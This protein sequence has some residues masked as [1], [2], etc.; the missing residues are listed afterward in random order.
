MRRSW[1]V[2]QKEIL[3]TVR[4]S[5][6][7]LLAFVLPLVMYPCIFITVGQVMRTNQAKEEQAELRV[8]IA[9]AEHAPGLPAILAAARQVTLVRVEL[10]PA[11]VRQQLVEV[12]V[13]VPPGHEAAVLAGVPS[14]IDLYYDQTDALSRRARER[15]EEALV[16]YREHLL[17]QKLS[18]LGG[19]SGL[20]DAPRVESRNVASAQQM[21]AYVLGTLVPYLLVILIA[22]A[23]SHTAIDTT[24][25]EKERSTLET[26]L[27]SAAT[28]QELLI[29]KFLA[30]FATAAFA[31]IMGLLG[32][33]L[34]LS[35]PASAQAFASTEGQIVLPMW[36]IGVLL[37]MILP[38]A[39]LLSAILLVF[40][41]FARSAREGQ[42]F[43]SYF[44][45]LVAVIAVLSVTSEVQPTRE[46]FLIPI[47][48]TTQVQRLILSG[49]AVPGDVFLA[50]ASTIFVA[51]L[52]V[53]VALRLFANE[54]VMFR[55]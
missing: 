31:G 32:L 23:A 43:A 13:A 52:G 15:V 49:S 37:L 35:L 11:A 33:T 20:V 19:D 21:G 47:L 18:G 53:W 39:A 48:G 50:I 46:V 8:A 30:T 38:V 41:C 28:R 25:G 4:D 3:D 40:G 12:V 42:T 9:G 1:I 22:S 54:R 7:L 2:G 36:S 55:Q 27:V 45:M 5:R 51:A 44:I 10:G 14:T 34:T 29:G 17:R 16:R 26:I 24:A 6:T